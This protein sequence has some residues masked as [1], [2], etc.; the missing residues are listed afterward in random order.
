MHVHFSIQDQQWM[1]RCLDLAQ[2]GAGYVS[3]NPQV[4]AVLVYQNRI[5]GEGYHQR[6][7]GPHAEVNA[8]N[9]VG[10]T[11][12]PYIKEATLYVSL[13]PCSFHGK[14][15]ACTDLI[16]RHQI[17]K[18]IIGCTDASKKVNGKGIQILLKHGVK[19]EVGLLKAKA[20]SLIRSFLT[21]D[22]YQ[23]P[24][25]I[26]KFAQSQNRKMGLTDRQI[27]LSGPMAKRIV[28]KWRHESDAILVGRQTA[29][30]D[31]PSLTNR[32]YFGNNPKRIVFDSQG[33]LPMHLNLFQGPPKTI[34]LTNQME[35]P[36]PKPFLQYE[37]TY[38]NPD[39]WPELL[40]KLLRQHRIGILLV[41]GGAHTIQGFLDRGLWDEAR[42]I[43]TPT[44]I[45][46]PSVSAP[47][48]PKHTW[49][50]RHDLFPDY[51]DFFKN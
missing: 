11:D 29:L 42:V 30:M 5:I 2:L 32:L 9:A 51:I 37:S 19:V 18:V 27:W 39:Q 10:I 47:I 15:P 8:V 17:P 35:I 16:L 38:G 40:T 23:R 1:Q 22:Y 3:P 36:D 44:Q 45:E 28:H 41:E 46:G 49:Q 14:T 26:L 4:G 31:N 43:N 33:T 13:E 50:Y 20:E 21:N 24:Y 7:G 12:R 48:I 25:I 6:F 34:V